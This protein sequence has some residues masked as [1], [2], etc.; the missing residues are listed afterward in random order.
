MG[1]N[2]TALVAAF[3]A[4]YTDEGQTVQSIKKQLFEAQRDESFFNLVPWSQDR[5]KSAYATIDG[6]L[7][8]FSIPFATK[9]TTT[10]KPNYVDL[11]EFKIDKLETPDQL[12]HTWLGFLAN[13]EEAK[14]ADWPIILWIIREM[15]IPKAKEEEISQV[16]WRGWKY[17]GFDATPVVD[18]STFVRELTDESTVNPA[19]ASGDGIWIQMLKNLSRLNVIATGA[20][21]TDPATFCTQVEDFVAAIP[22]ALRSR[23][24]YLFMA[25]NLRNRYADGR[26][27]KY[28]ANYLQEADLVAIKNSMIKVEYLRAMDGSDKFFA[29][30]A[31][32]RVRPTHTDNTGM[33]DVQPFDRQVK[34][35]S[36]WKKIWAFD[37]PEYVVTNDLENT[38]TAQNI[39]DYYTEA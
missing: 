3:N 4:V 18:G 25:E 26:R 15:I 9:G 21:S 29:T 31:M 11:G 34:L 35:L 20:L 12:R 6:V 22:P 16:L 28:N 30:P 1:Y 24:D 23:I 19:N 17:T 8:A 37:V 10:F 7:Q 27:V 32:N 39:T 14:R 13:I 2:T 33:F 5:Y 38:I 36:D